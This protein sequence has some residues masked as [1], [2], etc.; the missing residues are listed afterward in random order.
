M[1]LRLPVFIQGLDALMHAIQKW[2]GG[3]VVIS[4]DERFITTVASE[5]ITLY[6]FQRSVKLTI[7]QLWVCGNQTV[8]KFKGNVEAYKVSLPLVIPEL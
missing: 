7:S 6:S 3:V 5:V 2:D 8:S 4:H 1:G